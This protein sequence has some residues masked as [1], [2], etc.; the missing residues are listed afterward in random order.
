[1]FQQTGP[2]RGIIAE[3]LES[4]THF[5]GTPIP[6]VNPH[7][8]TLYKPGSTTVTA[9]LP[10]GA[11]TWDPNPF[12]PD[13]LVRYQVRGDHFPGFP[14]ASLTYSDGTNGNYVDVPGWTAPAFP[15][16]Y[17]GVKNVAPQTS[18]NGMAITGSLAAPEYPSVAS[19][20]NTPFDV[21]YLQGPGAARGVPNTYGVGPYYQAVTQQLTTNIAPN[22]LYTLS[23][24]VGWISDIGTQPVYQPDGVTLNPKLGLAVPFF[25]NVVSNGLALTLVSSNIDQVLSAFNT[26]GAGHFQTLTETFYSGSQ[27][28][29]NTSL[30][31]VLGLGP[32]T[33][34]HGVETDFTNVNLSQSPSS[35][36]SNLTASISSSGVT[37]AAAARHF[38]TR[39]SRLPTPTRARPSTPARLARRISSSPAPLILR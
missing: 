24:D 15:A 6:I 3:P 28:P 32:Q 19:D 17:G 14:I 33:G 10:G 31:V 23:V 20:P 16:T 1:M 27:V 18:V 30:S 9:T 2:S 39:R 4:R 22:T 5:D 29:A 7:F 25:A 13:A 11:G 26:V 37:A 21:L 12:G 35:A 8:D 38:R 34:G 36:A